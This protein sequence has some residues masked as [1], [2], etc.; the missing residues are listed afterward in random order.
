M[1]ARQFRS[2][3]TDKFECELRVCYCTKYIELT[4]DDL[5]GPKRFARDQYGKCTFPN[6]FWSICSVCW[7]GVNSVAQCSTGREIPS[8]DQV[9]RCHYDCDQSLVYLTV[10]RV[11]LFEK[12]HIAHT[13]FVRAEALPSRGG[14]SSEWR[15]LSFTLN[16]H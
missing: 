1:V 6:W 7:P 2:T 12:R 10:E 15:P 5:R 4:F 8:L 3:Q 13:S 14:V 11:C 9:F 16:M